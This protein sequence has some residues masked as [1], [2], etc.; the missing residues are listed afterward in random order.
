[1]SLLQVAAIRGGEHEPA[2]EP[3]GMLVE[4]L[5]HT[6]AQRNPAAL[7]VGFLARFGAAL[8]MDTL[9]RRHGV[10]LV[11]VLPFERE[12]LFG[13]HAGADEEDGDRPVDGEQFV[14]DRLP[15]I[16]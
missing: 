3:A 9:D 11:D 12:R 6:S 8:R 5:E 16:P 15:L 14:R 10:L 4:R 7:P 2:V 13:T 1:M